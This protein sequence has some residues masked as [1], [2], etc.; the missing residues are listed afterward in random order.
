MVIVKDGR[1][2]LRGSLILLAGAPLLLAG[3]NDSTRSFEPSR[4]A[5]KGPPPVTPVLNAPAFPALARNGEI[6]TGAEHIYEMVASYHG[7]LVSRYVFYADSSFALQ[8]S[9]ARFGFFEYDGR[10]SRTDSLITFNWNG[11]SAAGRWEA[12]G[13]LRGDELRVRY[14][15]I[16]WLTDFID[17]VYVR[18]PA[19]R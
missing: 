8:F 5:D 2:R 1:W 7:K 4:P 14:N 13:T 17:G 3:C 19:T 16:M 11:W 6:Y 10:F 9:S 12:T 15:L 18:L